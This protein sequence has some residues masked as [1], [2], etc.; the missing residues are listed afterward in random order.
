MGVVAEDDFCKK[1]PCSLLS[2]TTA[3]SI[4]QVLACGIVCDL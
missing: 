1:R 4:S 2:H 3:N